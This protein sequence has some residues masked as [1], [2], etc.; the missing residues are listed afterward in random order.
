MRRAFTLIELLVVIAIIAVLIALLLPAVQQA[1]EAARRMQ[2]RNNL[3]QLGLALHNYEASHRTFPPN[4]V[5]GANYAYSAGNWG[6]LAYLSPY[7]DQTPIYNLM[8]LNAPTYASTSPYNIADP[9]NALAASYVIPMFLCPSDKAQSLGGDYGVAALGPANYCA[10][11]GS[12]INTLAG[13]PANGSPYNADGV[14]FANSRIRIADITDGTSNTA[15]MSESLLGEGARSASGTT[16]PVSAQKSYA[17]LTTY[18]GS[19]DDGSCA[20]ASSWNIQDLRQFLWYS[21][22]IRNTSYNHY[23]TPNDDR[24]DC[25]TNAA[26][27]GYTAIGWKA[28]RSLHVGG[29]HLLLC[30]G[31]VRFVSDEIYSSTWR[32]LST[33]SGGEIVGEF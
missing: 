7:L 9:N 22:E 32:S 5:P 2:C 17:Y 31:S 15:C 8:N 11:M 14:M 27:L 19:L 29:V 20:S 12:G 4:L 1:R 25:I 6:V 24:W 21:G 23:Y 13:S 18:Q 28:A 26:T 3:K 16:P 10:N 30:D 33:R